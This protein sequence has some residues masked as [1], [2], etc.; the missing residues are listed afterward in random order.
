[1]GNRSNWVVSQYR[2]QLMFTEKKMTAA[3]DSIFAKSAVPP[4]IIIQADHG[5]GSGLRWED[6]QGTDVR[7][8]LAILNAY[9]LPGGGDTL[10]YYEVSPVNTFRIV[11]NHYFGTNYELLEDKSYYSRLSRPFDF[12]DVT[13]RI[14]SA[15]VGHRTSDTQR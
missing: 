3:L 6:V 13:D 10:L 8:R 15:E 14:R 11:F 9:Y 7:E 2:E 4:I 5:P 12:I 1:M